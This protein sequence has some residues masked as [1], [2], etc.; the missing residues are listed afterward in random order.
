MFDTII[1]GAG[2]AGLS[3][4]GILQEKQK[5]LV[6][7]EYFHAGGRLLGQLYEE[8]K[9]KWWNGLEIARKLVSD[10]QDKT[11]IR[12]S[13]SVY[14]VELDDTYTV[15]TTSGTF[16]SR[17]L[18]I[19]TG[20]REK[21]NPLPEWDLPGVMTVGAA[22]VLTNFSRVRPGDKG[23]IVG[24]NPLSMV[25]AMELGYADIDVAKICLPPENLLSTQKPEDAFETLVSLGHSAP[26]RF[27]STGAG[28]AGKA[29]PIHPAALKLFPKNGIRAMGLPISIKEKIIRIN[30]TEKVESVTVQKTDSKGKPLNGKT[31][32]VK[33][34]FVCISD[35]LA[36]LSE[37]GSLLNL[38]HVYAESL[39]G[40]VPLHSEMMETELPNLYVAGNV[41]GIEN[42]KVA[43]YQGQLAAHKIL[44]DEDAAMRSLSAITHER[45]NAKVKFHKDLL[46]GRE[47][48]ETMWREI[49]KRKAE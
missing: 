38:K 29:K 3:A 28:L 22:Q 43:M 24:I 30:G 47:T 1:I 36:P 7:D 16:R 13:T 45:K 48:V 15:H 2:P 40:Y 6:L 10:T 23:V 37:I 8:K 31:R 49:E 21:S 25:I 12:L 4:A 27:I 19:A 44:G 9:G 35:G 32:E 46:Q 26:S 41:T 11:E 20:S 17:H 42:A 34:D 14:D 39:G 33:C 18:I 5:V